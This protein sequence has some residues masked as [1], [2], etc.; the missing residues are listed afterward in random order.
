MAKRLYVGNLPW[1]T[2][3]EELSNLFGQHG[4]VE[5]SKVII[6]NQTGRSRGFGFVEVADEDSDKVIQALNG[7]S[8]GSRDLTVNEARPRRERTESRR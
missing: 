3:D 2:T 7:F 4:K 6:D 5:S 1:S 8:F